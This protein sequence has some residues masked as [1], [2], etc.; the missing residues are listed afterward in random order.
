MLKCICTKFWVFGRY[1]AL[2]V[3]A[4]FQ[5]LRLC[6][7]VVSHTWFFSGK[8][9]RLAYKKCDEFWQ[10]KCHCILG[11]FLQQIFPEFKPNSITCGFHDFQTNSSNHSSVAWPLIFY[12]LLF[13]T[14]WGFWWMDGGCIKTLSGE[15][16]FL[17][18]NSARR[19]SAPLKNLT[20]TCL[21]MEQVSDNV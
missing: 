10:T 14:D 9:W 16:Y 3:V 6:L 21:C 7:K 5:M 11:L 18:W 15:A 12:L 8:I 20:W 2:P 1:S 19:L 17:N 4:S 13:S